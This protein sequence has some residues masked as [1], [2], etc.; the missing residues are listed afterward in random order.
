MDT[1]LAVVYAIVQAITEFLP[2]SSSGHLVL[3][4]RF[5][6]L[7]VSSEV[8]FDV[9]LHAGTL[10]AIMTYF[11]KD[12]WRTLTTDRRML[13][14]LIISAIPGGLAGVLFEDII[15]TSLRSPWVVVVMLIVVGIIFFFVE[16]YSKQSVTLKEI[17]LKQ[18]LL[19]SC[20]QVLAL[21]PGTSRSGI[22]ISTAMSLGLKRIDAARFSFLMAVPI[23]LGATAKKTLDVVQVG[24]Q[25]DELRL[26]LIGI[27]VSAVVGLVVIKYLLSFLQKYSL[28]TFGWYRIALALVVSVLLLV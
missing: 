10:L 20:A 18:V 4:H 8:V 3:L 15:D 17:T 9:A 12:L 19:I 26:L 2:V 21:I 24:I 16:S 14:L 5:L 1:I 23:M 11:A 7:E 22:T 27:V 6:P 25:A 13:G 28:R